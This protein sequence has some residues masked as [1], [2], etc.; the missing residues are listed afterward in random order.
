MHVKASTTTTEAPGDK[1][2]TLSLEHFK[3]LALASM[4][5]LLEYYEFTVFI[6]LT[7]FTS[8]LF[9]PASS[10]EW[11]RELETLTI[12]ASGYLTR[13]LGGIWLASLGDKLGRK[14]M[15]AVS[16]LLMAAPTLGVGLLPV[17]AQ[18]GVCAPLGLLACRLLQGAALGGELPTA[19]VFVS[20]HVPE[21]RLG[22]AFGVLGTGVVL[23]FVLASGVIT[24]LLHHMGAEAFQMRGWRVPFILGGAFGL[25]SAFL[26]RYVSETPVF[27]DLSARRHLVRG[28]PFRQLF[29]R[30]KAETILCLLL[31]IAPGVIVP[32]VH[33]FPAIYLQTSLH[34]NARIVNDA[35]FWLQVT[36]LFS[37]I[38]G[39]LAV[40]L[41]GWRSVIVTTFLALILTLFGFYRFVT[42]DNLHLWFCALGLFLS[43]SIMLYNPLVASFPAQVRMTGI[44]SVYNVGAA[45][46][47]G[48]TPVVMQILARYSKWGLP[49]YPAAAAT[50][51]I[52]VTPFLWKM[53][54]PVGPDE[55]A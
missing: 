14:K 40:D 41:L 16:V 8:R 4:G 31:S 6:F 19:M 2:E 27:R 28:T 35:L 43:G 10:P 13:P 50:I 11:L 7:P 21:R 1:S 39:G 23:G 53:R 30:Y 52:V 5:G 36:M 55:A 45:V 32:G 34:Y 44:A 54:K 3:V 49:L 26:R 25:V 20:E 48:T 9:F 47:G 15:F 42:P 38:I 12:F 22:L 24:M 33:L 51:A 29:K 18:I 17:Y 46:F 37:G